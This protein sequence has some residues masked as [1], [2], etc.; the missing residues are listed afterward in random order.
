M[1]D[2][3]LIRNNELITDDPIGLYHPLDPVALPTRPKLKARANCVR[4]FRHYCISE[5]QIIIESLGELQIEV[6]IMM[7]LKSRRFSETLAKKNLLPGTKKAQKLIN[8]L[9]AHW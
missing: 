5:I 7:F 6:L 9:C 8:S 4:S 3:F 2:L 1:Q